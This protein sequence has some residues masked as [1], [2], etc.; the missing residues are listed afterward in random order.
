MPAREREQYRLKTAFRQ[1]GARSTR[2]VR[3]GAGC[4]APEA[5]F[6]RWRTEGGFIW[7]YRS[8]W[9][10]GVVLRNGWGEGRLW[11]LGG[12]CPSMTDAS[13]LL[14]EAPFPF[15]SLNLKRLWILSV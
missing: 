7:V 2:S 8:V 6:G 4:G 1:T 14:A 12:P 3:C 13:V 15:N 5:D 9:R 10:G 11:G